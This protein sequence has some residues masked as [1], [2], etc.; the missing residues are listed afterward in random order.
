MSC[1]LL[2]DH[3]QFALIHG[4]DISGSYEILLFTA[5]NPAS[6]TSHIHKWV[7]FLLWFCLFILSGVISPWIS[8]GILD[9]FRPREFIFQCPIFFPFHTIHGVLKPRIL[10]WFAIPFSS[11]PRRDHKEL[12]KTLEE[13]RI[14]DHLNCLVRNLYAGQQPTVRTWYGSVDWFKIEK[15]VCQGCILSLCL[16]N[17]YAEYIMRNARLDVLQAGI[18]IARRNFNNLRYADDNHSNGR[19]QRGTNETLDES[20]RGEWKS[21]LKTQNKKKLRSWHPAPSLHGK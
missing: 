8:S 14:P 2:F 15:G 5:P 7:L 20:E 19:K 4:P 6:I 3:F 10:K 9:T 11:G 1:H 17:F 13:M 21:H 16:F 18:K 12:W